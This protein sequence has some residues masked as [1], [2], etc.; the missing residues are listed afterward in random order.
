LGARARCL[1]DGSSRC[2]DVVDAPGSPVDGSDR[3]ALAAGVEAVLPPAATP[4]LLK[5][6]GA[7]AVLAVGEHTVLEIREPGGWRLRDVIAPTPARAQI[8]S[9]PSKSPSSSLARTA[10][11]KRAA[12]APSTIRWS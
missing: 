11:R 1:A 12:S 8:P 4:V 6:S 2:L 7:T 5:A 3:A 9:E 10:E